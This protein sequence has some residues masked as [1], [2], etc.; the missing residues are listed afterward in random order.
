MKIKTL[1]TKILIVFFVLIGLCA[2]GFILLN[3]A[4]NRY[5]QSREEEHTAILETMKRNRF[6]HQQIQNELGIPTGLLSSEEG[7]KQYSFSLPSLDEA[8]KKFRKYPSVMLYIK[9]DMIYF[10]FLDK[11]GKMA[12]FSLG[13]S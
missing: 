3:Y 13:K 9:G 2:I 1:L 10:I 4:V 5:H 8:M 11:E 7:L 12:D 6:S